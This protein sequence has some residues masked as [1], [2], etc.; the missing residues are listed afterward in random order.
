MLEA[1]KE[2]IFFMKTGSQKGRNPAKFS[3]AGP[4]PE[5]ENGAGYPVGSYLS[6]CYE[7]RRLPMRSGS[8]VSNR[9]II[10]VNQSDSI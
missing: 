9:I 2:V 1:L 6:L 8:V 5:P 7:Y 10:L 3:S 4:E